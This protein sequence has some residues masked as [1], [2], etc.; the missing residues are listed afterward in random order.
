MVAE[1]DADE[2][3][4]NSDDE[5]RLYKAKKERYSKKRRA[6]LDKGVVRKQLKE[7][8]PDPWMYS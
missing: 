2:L 4:D 5:K 1:H 3:A 7:N 6:A 8:Q